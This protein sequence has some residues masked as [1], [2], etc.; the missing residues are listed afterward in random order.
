M[1]YSSL[2]LMLNICLS[3][4]NL[5]SDLQTPLFLY[6]SLQNPRTYLRQTEN[7]KCK[8]KENCYAHGRSLSI[9]CTI[10]R[11]IAFTL[12]LSRFV[13]GGTAR[14]FGVEAVSEETSKVI[15]CERRKRL[16]IKRFGGVKDSEFLDNNAYNSQVRNRGYTT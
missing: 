4:K 6:F 7:L 2:S 5:V 16:A 9:L 14:F 3:F 15:W 10:F 8:R 13:I 11:E 1:K 12:F